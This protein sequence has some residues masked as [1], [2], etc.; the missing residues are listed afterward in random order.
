MK[1]YH[2][3]R[4][5]EALRN[6]PIILIMP[7]FWGGLAVA[8]VWNHPMGKWGLVV[9]IL[10][11]LGIIICYFNN[12][13]AYILR[14]DAENLYIRKKKG[15]KERKTEINDIALIQYNK[16]SDLISDL[17]YRKPCREII[18]IFSKIGKAVFICTNDA[19]YVEFRKFFSDICGRI[20]AEEVFVYAKQ[21]RGTKMYRSLFVNP[22]YKN[23]RIVKKK[24]RQSAFYY[25]LIILIAIAVTF[26]LVFNLLSIYGVI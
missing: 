17:A 8:Y 6:I 19:D 1:E 16:S 15:G 5:N 11:L 7:L 4:L 21:I 10:S 18:I 26:M 9:I 23:S 3:E 12:N 22:E 13:K 20:N 14:I 24:T 25:P 2:L